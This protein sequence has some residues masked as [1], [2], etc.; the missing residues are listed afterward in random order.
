[1]P[2]TTEHDKEKYEKLLTAPH[3]SDEALMLLDPH[4]FRIEQA[5][6]EHG[7]DRFTFRIDTLQYS[8]PACLP[9]LPTLYFVGF[10]RPA[11]SEIYA[12]FQTAPISNNPY[13]RFRM[14][15]R[16]HLHQKGRDIRTKTFQPKTTR[17]ALDY[18]GFSDEAQTKLL[19]LK[20]PPNGQ[21]VEFMLRHVTI[22][23]VIEWVGRYFDRRIHILANLDCEIKKRENIDKGG[24]VVPVDLK[25][26]A[27]ELENKHMDSELA[28][29]ND[30]M[31][32]LPLTLI[33]DLP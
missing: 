23:K 33:T 29:G 15:A 21:R 22:D 2:I 17:E 4:S 1:M 19:K 11:A 24:N 6:Y 26:L 14:I 8:I 30:I 7:F 18:M 28:Y 10:N 25:F 9:T 16:V 20:Y 5:Y 27:D 12:K 32:P 3:L 31:D 13:F